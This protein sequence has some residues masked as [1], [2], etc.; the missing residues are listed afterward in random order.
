METGAGEQWRRSADKVSTRTEYCN[1]GDYWYLHDTGRSGQPI[2][3]PRSVAQRFARK[4]PAC[5]REH[6]HHDVCMLI[7]YYVHVRP[8]R[9]CLP[10]GSSNAWLELDWICPALDPS[11][12]EAKPILGM[13]GGH[14]GT[15]VFV[16]PILSWQLPHAP[17]PPGHLVALRRLGEMH[18]WLHVAAPISTRS[19]SV[20]LLCSFHRPS[21]TICGG[22]HPPSN[23]AYRNCAAAR[24]AYR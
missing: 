5:H 14:P 1:G 12:R 7:R 13:W 3:R 24:R 17:K 11:H 10:F 23:T 21:Y 6:F 4:H 15:A 20:P 22:T 18:R 19:A 9:S 8:A 2:D 16:P